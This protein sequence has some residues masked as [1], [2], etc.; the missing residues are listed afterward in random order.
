MSFV[1]NSKSRPLFMPFSQAFAPTRLYQHRGRP[2]A[3]QS[4]GEVPLSPAIRPDVANT[5]HLLCLWSS[6][7]RVTREVQAMDT[8]VNG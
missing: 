4:S 1:L 6:S 3:I 8:P 7:S 2:R 5:I